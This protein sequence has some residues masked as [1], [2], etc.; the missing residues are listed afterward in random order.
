MKF[1]H[2]IEINDPHN[3]HL[4]PLTRQQ[5]W[6]GLVLRAEAPQLFMPQLDQCFLSDPTDT[7]VA[8]ALHY[9]NLV[10]RDRVIF[11]ALQQVRFEVPAQGEIA[12]SSLVM[13]I[14]EAQ[15]GAL[16]VRFEYD[17]GCDAATDAAN[18]MYN[19]YRRATYH[20]ADTDTVALIRELAA[21]GAL[22]R[23]NP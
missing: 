23:P 22:V 21:Q 16:S 12:A 4:A 6:L 9:G 13:R 11:D 3:P 2:S 20:A 7:T 8:R 14:E 18:E 17:D 15:P 10:I 1:S 19:E 5:L